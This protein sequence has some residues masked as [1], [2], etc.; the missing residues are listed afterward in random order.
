[1]GSETDGRKYQ[2][3][4]A[5]WKSEAA[6]LQLFPERCGI[7]VAISEEFV[8][9]DRVGVARAVSGVVAPRLPEP[10]LE[11]GGCAAMSRGQAVKRN[12]A[13]H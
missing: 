11:A 10:P 4:P 9:L 12:R 6:I 13:T 2:A 8:G 7:G 1:M 3:T 5:L